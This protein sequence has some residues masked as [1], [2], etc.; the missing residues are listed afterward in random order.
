MRKNQEVKNIMF[1]GANILMSSYVVALTFGYLIVIQL[2]IHIRHKGF[3]KPNSS[4]YLKGYRN[5]SNASL[6]KSA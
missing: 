5:I 4:L 3:I 6:V 1:K 2:N